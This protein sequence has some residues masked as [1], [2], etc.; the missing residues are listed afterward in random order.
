MENVGKDLG[1]GSATATLPAIIAPLLGSII[2]YVASIYGQTALGYRLVFATATL[3]LVLAAIF[4]LS[5]R[6][7]H[8]I[9]SGSEP[10]SP[11][12]NVNI[13]WQL[14]FQTRAGKARGFLRFWPFLE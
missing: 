14:A 5:V 2:I 11:R 4:V 10:Q 7:R 13:G 12:R 6:E 3:F 9:H 8:V 1:I